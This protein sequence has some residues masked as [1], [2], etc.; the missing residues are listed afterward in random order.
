MYSLS[1][2]DRAGQGRQTQLPSKRHDSP[3]RSS[4]GDILPRWLDTRSPAMGFR[5]DMV[6]HRDRY[7]SYELSVPV[8]Y[9]MVG[10]HIPYR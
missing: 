8:Q 2:T 1:Q 6:R 3:Y 4:W 9:G 5:I 7:D 10:F